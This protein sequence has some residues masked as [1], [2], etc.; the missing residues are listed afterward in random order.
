MPALDGSLFG[1]GQPCFGCS[2]DHPSGFRLSFIEE[3]DAP[4]ATTGEDAIPAPTLLTRFTPRES[5][6]GPPG[7][8]HGG[9]VLTLADELAAWALIVR[10]GK[11][12]FT[13]RVAANLVRPTRV[14]VEIEG[15][16]RISRSTGRTAEVQVRLTQAG[17]ET[18][19]GGLTFVLLDRA[20]AEKMLGRP[21]PEEWARYSR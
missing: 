18:F 7:V 10:L 8:M 19:R 6:Q 3:A 20:A 9:L 21:L 15:R 16:A 13:A 12:G 1:P 5:D 17:I 2:P 11:F 14:G 4:A